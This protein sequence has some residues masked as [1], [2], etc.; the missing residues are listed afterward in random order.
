MSQNTALSIKLIRSKAKA[1]TKAVGLFFTRLL[2][3]ASTRLHTWHEYNDI[4]GGSNKI[5]NAPDKMQFLDNRVRFLYP[6]FLVYMGEI[7]LQF[8]NLKNCFSFLQS[9]SY[10]NILCHVFNSARNNQQQ[11]VIFIHVV[12]SACVC[13]GGKER[14][15]F[16]L[17]KTK[18]NAK[19]Y[20]E[21]MLPE[22]V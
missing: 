15:H 20:V 18:V 21:T 13:F 1:M 10:I 7:L 6:N 8:W 19:L 3:S 2:A 5:P 11:L 9:Y 12:V 17:D 22:L 14:L 16:I 4:Q